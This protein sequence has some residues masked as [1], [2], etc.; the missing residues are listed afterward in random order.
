MSRVLGLLTLFALT[1]ACTPAI[2][3]GRFACAADDDCPPGQ[4]CALPRGRC[5]LPD[6][7]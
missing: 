7:G 2:P 4:R 1:S 3:D 5:H 6:G